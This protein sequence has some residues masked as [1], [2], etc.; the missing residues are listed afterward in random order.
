MDPAGGFV[1]LAA[2]ES[3]LRGLRFGAA[4]KRAG[5]FRAAQESAAK[6]AQP[7]RTN[8]RCRSAQSANVTPVQESA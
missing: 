6:V 2:G 3:W 4:R 1:H 7:V 5:A 8:Q